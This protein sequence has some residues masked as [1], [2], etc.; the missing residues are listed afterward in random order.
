MFFEYLRGGIQ[1][2]GRGEILEEGVGEDEMSTIERERAGG[3]EG[4][5]HDR[6]VVLYTNE[7][8]SRRPIAHATNLAS[9]KYLRSR[10]SDIRIYFRQ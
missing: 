5:C 7:S 10:W 1:G 8:A 6:V 3:L 4:T 2:L 9:A